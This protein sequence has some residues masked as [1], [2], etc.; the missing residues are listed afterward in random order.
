MPTLH[1][2]EELVAEMRALA[3]RAYP[4]EACGLLLGQS[5]PREGKGPKIVASRLHGARNVARPDGQ[6][7][8]IDPDAFLSAHEAADAAG[9]AVL[10]AWHSHPDRPAEPSPDDIASAQ[11]GW[12]T[13]IVAVEDGRSGG[14]AAFLAE[15][16]E[17]KEQRTCIC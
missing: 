3:E 9:L 5:L 13:V 10:G 12:W 16:A 4:A 17:L 15:G 14:W 6:R 1:V 7:F 11:P 8:Q 2:S